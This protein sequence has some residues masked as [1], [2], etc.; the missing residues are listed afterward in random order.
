MADLFSA[1]TMATRSL[2]A[3]RYALEVVGH[4]LAN[5]NTPGYTHR[6][7]NLVE[8]PPLD[9]LGVGSGVDVLG[10]QAARAPLIEHR[11]YQERPAAGR[12]RAV[13]EQLSIIESGLGKPGSALDARLA[14]FFDAFASLAE[15]PTSSVARRLVTLQ[16]SSLAR[17]F[18]DLSSEF[19][20]AGVSADAQVRGTIETIN[21]LARDIASLN[22]AIVAA[23]GGTQEALLDRRGEALRTLS[24]LVD[25]GV[26]YHDDAGIDVTVGNGRA[27]VAGEIAYG[28]T[29]TP[30]AGV[31]HITNNSLDITAE[32]TGGRLGGYMEVR[33]V[34]VPGYASRL[35]T[36][37]YSFVGAV[38]TQ[39]AAGFD[40]SGTAGGAFFTPLGSVTGAAAAMSV[41]A[42]I[43][44]DDRTIAASS[45]ATYT[46]DNQNARALADLR[47]ASPSA[48]D[49][50]GVLVHRVAADR[51][52][53]LAELETREDVLHQIE[54]LRAQISGVSIDEEAAT[55][56]RFQRAYEAN[57]RF[58]GVV[59]G[60][61]EE[62]LFYMGR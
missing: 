1:L 35:D 13:S 5:V 18:R 19:V 14:E 37:A 58:F 3:N 38:N 7:A 59:D 61:L 17:A 27:L 21:G 12:E 60:L 24:E 52:S 30:V 50:W 41:S 8:V 53:A 26:T 46:G 55:M 51:Q 40:L 9:L 43:L 10:V 11:L 47:N 22:V 23:T 28:L 29:A 48:I 2:D 39:H 42:A 36:L 16:G 44:A 57:A 6:A 62:M 56:L 45:S 54:S 25:I 34:L 20:N 49:D 33:D 15:E 4:N 32:I 31:T